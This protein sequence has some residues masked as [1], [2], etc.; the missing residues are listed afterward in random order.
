MQKQ[1]NAWQLLAGFHNPVPLQ[2]TLTW[3][4]LEYTMQEF[5]LRVVK[6]IPS[7]MLLITQLFT[8]VQI[9]YKGFFHIKAGNAGMITNA[10]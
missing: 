8:R 7:W 5:C 9:V 6:A 1:S 10:F 4:N 2:K 3:A